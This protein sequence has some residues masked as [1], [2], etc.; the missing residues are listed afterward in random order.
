MNKGGKSKVNYVYK[1]RRATL[2]T[3]LI[4]FG[5]LL[6]IIAAI[7][8]IVYLDR[9]AYEDK[10][11]GDISPLDSVYFTVVSITT[12]GYGDIVPMEQDARIIDTVF[13]TIG[14]AALWFVIVG[15]AYQFIFERY[16]EAI[17]MNSMRRTLNDHV[18]I[19]GYGLTGRTAA[20]ELIAKGRKKRY[21][22]V[23][24]RDQEE[25]RRAAEDGF[26][27][28]SGDPSKEDTLDGAL[29]KKA[30]SVIITTGRDDTNV[31]I[32]LTARDL[33]PDVK[34]IS[35]VTDLENRK[36]LLK[37]GVDV[38]IAPQVTGGNLMAT[39]TSNPN[40]VHLL[41]DVM[42]ASK[43][44]YLDERSPKEG[45][46]GR[47]VGD[48]KYTTVLGVARGGKVISAS[49]GADLKLKKSDKLLILEGSG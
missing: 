30:S 45:E 41:E 2:K 22:V 24:S 44:Y 42:T 28:L 17:T 25:S 34:I 23:V 18:I 11:D 21:I 19:C 20:M 31:L 37:S 6:L 15:T 38:I 47:R 3:V 16:R 1:E 36:L 29:I 40:V 7:S 32:S 49:G 26:V 48:L 4:R 35:Q 9:D 46:V 43:G 5:A 12:T 14:R 13:I 27:S 10:K 8:T 39:A 33:N